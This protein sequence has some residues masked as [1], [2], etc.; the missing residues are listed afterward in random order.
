MF[1]YYKNESIRKLVIGFGNLFNNIQIEQ[2]NTDNSK[3]L[4]TVPLSYAPKEKFIKRL[5]EHSSISDNTRIEIGI[6]QMAFELA[7]LVYDPLR[8][9]NKLSKKTNYSSNTISSMY[10]ETP[11]NFVFNLYA[12]TRNIEENLQIL[13]QILPYFSPEFVI[14][15]NMNEINQSVDVPIVLSQTNLTQDYEGDFS[16]R[17]QVVTTYQFT[18]KSYVYGNI[19]NSGAPTSNVVINTS[20]TPFT[21]TDSYGLTA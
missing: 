4:F 6:P 8:R 19:V 9:M 12:Y 15:L 3:R 14:S 17:R 16:T 13:E 7:G 2:I 10:T 1:T 11:Y 21:F 18:A 5:T 20:D